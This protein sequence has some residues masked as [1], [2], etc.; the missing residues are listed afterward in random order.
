MKVLKHIK[1]YVEG[2]LFNYPIYKEALLQIKENTFLQQSANNLVPATKDKVPH[3]FL[4]RST[5]RMEASISAIEDVLSILPEK[6][7]RLIELRYFRSYKVG[8]VVDELDICVRNFFNYRDEAISFF[9]VRF[10]LI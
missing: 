6:Y 2:E 1:K 10:G 3:P 7:R 9:A 4:D 5:I 8:Q